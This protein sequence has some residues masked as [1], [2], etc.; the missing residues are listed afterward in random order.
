MVDPPLEVGAVKAMLALALPAVAKPMVGAPGTV[1]AA[2]AL[3]VKPAN[4]EKP[5]KVKTFFKTNIDIFIE[6][7]ANYPANG[8]KISICT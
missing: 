2:K 4:A 6:L 8:L 7:F 5:A 3:T 1:T